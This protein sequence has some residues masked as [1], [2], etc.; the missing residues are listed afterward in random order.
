M[1]HTGYH[2]FCSLVSG[3]VIETLESTLERIQNG[4]V[5]ICEV[6]RGSLERELAAVRPDSPVCF[7]CRLVKTVT[8]E[9]EYFFIGE[10]VAIY[11]DGKCMTGGKLDIKKIDPL[12][13]STSDRKYFRIGKE[14][15]K[16]YSMGRSK[17]G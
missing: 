16:A 10:M 9:N 7:E 12:I 13:Y 15:G 17:K 5:G 4:N 2:L 1:I 8:F 11:A 3:T 6:C 14:I